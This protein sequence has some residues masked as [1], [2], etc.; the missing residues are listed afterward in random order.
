MNCLYVLTDY[1]D[2]EALADTCEANL[3]DVEDIIGVSGTENSTR[4]YAEDMVEQEV[5][6]VEVINDMVV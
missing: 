2:C 5:Y 1:I 4:S 6:K 3:R